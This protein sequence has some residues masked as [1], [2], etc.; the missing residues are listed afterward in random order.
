MDTDVVT[1]WKK[2]SFITYSGEWKGKHYVDKGKIIEIVPG[3][4]FH[5]T[6]LS[7]MSGK[8]DKPENYAN[9]IYELAADGDNT[10]LT[11]TQDNNK[12]VEE[13]E[14]AEKNWKMVIGEMK[15]LLE[16]EAA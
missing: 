12:N 3:K 11:L 1:D 6:Y 14:Y 9:V 5:T 16:K 10:T 4:L 2:G 15:K 7:G 13:Q 8:A